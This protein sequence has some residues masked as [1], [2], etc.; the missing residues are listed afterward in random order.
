M[1]S[2]TSPFPSKENENYYR[3][4]CLLVEV[5][6]EVLRKTF[7]KVRPSGNLD[8][9]L[10]DPQISALLRS[11][12]KKE[13]LSSSQ[14]G[15]LYPLVGS[16]VSSKQFDIALLGILLTSICNLQPPETGWNE[17]PPVTDT[18]IQAD[19]TRVR[20]YNT[21]VRRP[22]WSSKWAKIDDRAFNFFWKNIEDTL[23]SLGGE[24]YR[25]PIAHLKRERLNADCEEHYGMFFNPKGANKDM[26]SLLSASL[27]I[28][29]VPITLFCLGKKLFIE[30]IYFKFPVSLYLIT[31]D[32]K[33]LSS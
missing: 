11:L 16:A 31:F 20:V 24:C 4:Y 17:F 33:T 14:W 10:A 2:A 32:L 18:T 6:S 28:S 27:K 23:V 25:K 9:L 21:M 30:C 5:G 12:R 19:I 1:A 26:E 15:K 8:K 7:D 13:V 29:L 22:P 3:L